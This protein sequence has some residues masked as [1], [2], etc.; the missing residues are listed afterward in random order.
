MD[1]APAR[2]HKQEP[3]KTDGIAGYHGNNHR[4]FHARQINSEITVPKGPRQVQ[5]EE[6]SPQVDR[7]RE[8]VHL[9]IKCDDKRLHEFG[10][11][12]FAPTPWREQW[13]ENHDTTTIEMA[14]PPQN[15]FVAIGPSPPLGF[16]DLRP[17][18][19]PLI[20]IG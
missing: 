5:V 15:T 2:D 3:K 6:A 14:A 12:P 17:F 20:A 18:A 9:A 19:P 8:A 7:Y 16:P 11:H 13:V 4:P 1:F 10:S